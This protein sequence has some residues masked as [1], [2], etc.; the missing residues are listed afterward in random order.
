MSCTVLSILYQPATVEEGCN[1]HLKLI[2]QLPKLQKE[3]HNNYAHFK[4]TEKKLADM[5]RS[6]RGCED[7]ERR[8]TRLTMQSWNVTTERLSK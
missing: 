6:C 4:N 3:R 8:T 7:S 2:Q 1:L 5:C